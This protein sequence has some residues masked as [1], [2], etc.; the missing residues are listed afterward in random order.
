MAGGLNTYGY[1]GGNPI[2]RIDPKGLLKVC[3]DG[4]EDED[5]SSDEFTPPINTPILLGGNDFRYH[6]NWCGPGWTGGMQGTWGEIDISVAEPPIDLLDTACMAHDKCY[7][8]CRD[9]NP[10]DK[11]L[12]GSCM[13][14]CDRGLATSAYITGNKGPLW[15][16]MLVNLNFVRISFI[17]ELKKG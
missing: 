14:M 15:I 2:L 5:C 12:R 16:W 7:Q 10:C 1:V 13:T 8:N 11:N 6:G 4:L 9:D 3:Y 17:L